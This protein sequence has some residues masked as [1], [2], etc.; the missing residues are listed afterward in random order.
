MAPP[1]DLAD[2]GRPKLQ[3]IV[4]I[5]V[6]GDKI[7]KLGIGTWHA[8]PHFDHEECL[9]LNLENMDTREQDF[10]ET[11]LGVTCEMA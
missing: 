2:K 6:P 4:G 10:H 7:L 3:D 11:D 9:F 5:R 8:G 1:G